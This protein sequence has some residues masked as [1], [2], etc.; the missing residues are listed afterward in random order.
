MT[1]EQWFNYLKNI[2]T[3]YKNGSKQTR[4]QQ[5]EGKIKEKYRKYKYRAKKKKIEFSLTFPEFKDIICNSCKYCGSIEKLTVDRV[6]N[7]SGYIKGNCVSCCV[8]CNSGKRNNLCDDFMKW[9][10][11]VALKWM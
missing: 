2:E 5:N 4:I 11:K 9:I 6:V 3:Y 1:Q 10:E 8:Y 7:S